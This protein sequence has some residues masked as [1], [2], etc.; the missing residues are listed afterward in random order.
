MSTPTQTQSDFQRDTR[1]AVE[2]RR[3]RAIV[4]KGIATYTSKVSETKA[5]YLDFEWGRLA[6]RERKAA[7]HAHLD[8]SLLAF[9]RA[10]TARGT[11]V[12]WAEDAAAARA[13]VLEIARRHGVKRVI[14]S[15]SMVTEEL[16]LNDFLAGQD[17]A[18]VE[19]DLGEYIVQLRGEKPFHIVT[20]AMHLSREDVG[21]T[22]QDKLGS[23]P[24][25]SAEGLTMEAR[26]VLRPEFLRA[27]MGITGANFLVAETGMIALTTNEG[28][29][30][31][32]LS[33]PRV[34]VAIAGIEKVIPR[35]QDLALFWPMLAVAGTGQQMTTY[36]TL[37]AGPRQPGEADGPDEFHVILLDNGR[38]RLLADP[39]QREAL[40]CIRCGACLN[41]CPVFA[42]V[43][44]HAYGTTYQ[45]PLGLVIMPHL[46]GLETYQHLPRASSLCGA[47]T[48]VC[49]VSIDL[50]HHLLRH[51]RN[52]VERGL[53]GGFELVLM[54]LLAWAYARAGRYRVA[55]ALAG[56]GRRLLGWLRLEGTWL[57]PARRWSAT[58]ALPP[59]PRQSFR[60]WW[61]TRRAP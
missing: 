47:C 36:N 46:R 48:E 18:A 39:E 12:H 33:L 59:F 11:Q 57:D 42:V 44:G 49:P 29:G 53:G 40:H 52:A 27:E 38:T 14:K 13:L 25:L 6:L 54:R 22:F 21:H 2:D 58:R 9:E 35:L 23:A 37:V 19:S 26:R 31:L 20:P 8:E 17:I 32:T 34:H 56:A 28:N 16:E 30:R 3:Q 15:K 7:A 51:R 61:A 4:A 5:Q 1:R 55:M 60:K 45:G 50:H 43:G 41:A 10:A 24:G